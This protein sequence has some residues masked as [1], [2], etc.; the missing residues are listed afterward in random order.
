MP[1]SS[2][3]SFLFNGSPPPSIT[4]NATSETGMPA[5][6]QDLVKG[7][8]TKA[9]AIAARPY[10]P[11][12]GERVAGL[13]PLQTQATNSIQDMQGAYTPSV[14]GALSTLGDI[15]SGTGVNNVTDAI[16]RLGTR[17]LS[18]NL[19]PAV[20]RSAIGAGQ[21]GGQRQSN[22]AERAV[23]DTGES[24][25][26][27]QAAALL[28]DQ[29]QRITAAA[30]VPTAA[31]AGQTLNLRD[32]AALDTAGQES[33]A[34]RQLQDNADIGQ[35]NEERD[36]P[37]T[38]VSNVSDV[39]RGLQVPTSTSSSSTGPAPV[40]GPSG[41]ATLAGSAL[42]ATALQNMFSGG[43]RRGGRIYRARGGL[44]VLRRR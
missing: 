30:A 24:V 6:Y 41:L 34:N 15:S 10:T 27:A 40:V 33:Q 4:T 42:T 43:H 3:S 1:D 28:Q 18:E 22:F 35:F 11:Y 38:Q 7:A 26:N 20:T 2:I 21:F 23:R 31:T 16:A 37:W 13:D 19:L 29:Q 17:N 12:T 14:Q 9:D 36:Y 5:W 25:L 8:A 44:S 39:I 32:A